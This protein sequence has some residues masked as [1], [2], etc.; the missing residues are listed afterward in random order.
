[1]TYVNTSFFSIFL[2]WYL[3]EQALSRAWSSRI[4]AGESHQET[5]L[6]N[7]DDEVEAFLKPDDPQAREEPPRLMIPLSRSGE[8]PPST[9]TIPVTPAGRLSLRATAVLSLEFCFLWFAANYSIAACLE[10]TTVASSTILMSTSSIWTLLFGAL[11]NVEKFTFTKAAGVFA[12][13]AGIILISSQD[14]SGETDKHRGTFPHKSTS[15]MATGN[16]LALGSAMLYGVYSILMK[17]R[18]GDES[19]VN[20]LLFFGLV[21]VFNILLSWPAFVILHFTGVEVFELPPTSRVWNIVL[22]SGEAS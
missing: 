17:K 11:I 10:Y 8:N 2:L 9:W 21:G 20:M 3:L 1:M 15:Q 13:L 12:S 5:L 16:A 22:A 14:F 4:Y 7:T 19:R 18:I 6:A